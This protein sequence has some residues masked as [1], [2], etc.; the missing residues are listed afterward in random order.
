MFF[1]AIIFFHMQFA[2]ARAR[3]A[4]FCTLSFLLLSKKVRISK[5][6]DVANTS[7]EYSRDTFATARAAS[8]S[9]FSF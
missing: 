7:L 2:A 8:C 6:P 3:A 4:F 1:R 5:A 9:T